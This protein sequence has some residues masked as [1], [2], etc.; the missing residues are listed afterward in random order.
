[1]SDF[2]MNFGN[3]IRTFQRGDQAKIGRVY[4]NVDKPSSQPCFCLVGKFISSKEG[5]KV[6]QLL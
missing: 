3:H 4:T 2:F 5:R 1:M 6:A